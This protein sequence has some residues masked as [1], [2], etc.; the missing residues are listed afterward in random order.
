MLPSFKYMRARRKLVSSSHPGEKGTCYLRRH[1]CFVTSPVVVPRLRRSY[2]WTASEFLRRY[3]DFLIANP[4]LGFGLTGRK[5]NRLPLAFI[6]SGDLPIQPAANRRP[7][8]SEHL[9]GSLAK[10][11]FESSPTNQNAKQFYNRYK[12]A[13]LAF[14]V[15]NAF[16]GCH[17][18]RD[19][20][21]F[22][23]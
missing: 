22:L 15:A 23:R 10:S 19:S 12:N 8:V 3:T 21:N 14:A 2:S 1:G 20:S 18:H 7:P 5:I 9:I 4:R 17:L 6:H 16:F 13:V 11:E